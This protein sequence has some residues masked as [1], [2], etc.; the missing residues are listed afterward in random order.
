LAAFAFAGSPEPL[1]GGENT[2][3]RVGDVVLKPVDVPD[4]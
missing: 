2:A 1:A 4:A 3:W